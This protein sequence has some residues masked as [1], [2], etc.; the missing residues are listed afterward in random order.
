MKL[1]IDTQ[2]LKDGFKILSKVLTTVKEN[3]IAVSV[4]SS[5]VIVERSNG[6]TDI[7]VLLKAQDTEN[8]KVILTN[9][10]VDLIKKLNDYE[11]V[12]IDSKIVT[13][14]KTVEHST[15]AGTIKYLS[16]ASKL[17]F[18]TTEN[19][20]HRMLQVK[21]AM[22][23]DDSRP[24]LAGV[25]FNMAETCAFDC[26]RLSLRKGSYI[27][28]SKFIVN[29]DTIKILDSILNVKK[30][31][32]IQV[33]YNKSEEV[34]TFIIGD[35]IIVTGITIPG[36]FFNYKSIIPKEYSCISKINLNELRNEMRS[37]DGIKTNYMKL[38]FTEDRLV[39]LI[40]Q[41]KEELD[42]EASRDKTNELQ[43]RNHNEYKRRYKAWVSRKAV[44]ENNKTEILQKC[45]KERMISPQ[46]VYRI[47]LIDPIKSE[48]DCCTEFQYGDTML[49]ITCNT[50]HIHQALRFHIGKTIEF[51]MSTSFDPI[52]IPTDEG[53]ELI[54][55]SRT[56]YDK[57][58]HMTV[59][60]WNM[61]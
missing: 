56:L 10:T 53:L 38:N 12:L 43:V 25:Y 30:D 8:G 17:A 44:A 2:I 32:D 3:Q 31:R 58:I 40:N 1:R 47:L 50:N 52:V 18:T 5:N 26:Y 34:A 39:M 54:I 51:K 29:E 60:R 27:S 4:T 9:R 33:Y 55:P 37:T 45:P 59:T 13:Q 21:Y 6:K 11:L 23:Q 35:E 49:D 22:A 14:S 57:L 61:E 46:I 15:I 20:L 41:Y 19:E 48:L 36:E 28:N 42:K 7:R 16:E 24:T